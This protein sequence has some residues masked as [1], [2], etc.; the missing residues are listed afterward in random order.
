[1]PFWGFMLVVGGT[2]ATLLVFIILS[3]VMA[4]RVK[5]STGLLFWGSVL[6]FAAMLALYGVIDLAAT[7]YPEPTQ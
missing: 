2:V 7:L 5:S 4:E 6:V 1:M 3:S